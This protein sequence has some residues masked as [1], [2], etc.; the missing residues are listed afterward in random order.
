MHL[1]TLTFRVDSRIA[2]YFVGKLLRACEREPTS[3]GRM[4]WLNADISKSAPLRGAFL[5]HAVTST[6]GNG[7][8]VAIGTIRKRSRD[9]RA[10]FQ[11]FF[12]DRK[13]RMFSIG[14]G[15]WREGERLIF[16]LE[17]DQC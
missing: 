1:Y 8:S 16:S 7:D 17:F 10:A 13:D 14:N 11:R 15:G 2:A 9:L 5:N 6:E 12:T 4:L 3:L